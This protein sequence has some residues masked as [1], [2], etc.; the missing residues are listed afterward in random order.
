MAE[1]KQGALIDLTASGKI[2]VLK[3]LGRG[4]QGIV[5]LSEFNGHK[6]ALK[7]YTQKYPDSFY[8]NIK[9][10]I[11]H[12]PPSKS[13]LWPLMLTKKQNGSFGYVMELRKNDFF[14]FGDYLLAKVKFASISAMINAALQI[15]EGF[16][17]LHLKGFSYQDLNDGNFFI[18]PQTGDVLICDNDNVTAQGSNTGIL[19]KARYMAPEIVLGGKPDKYS[20]YYSLAVMLFMLFYGNHPLEGKKVVNCPCMTEENERKHFGSEA[21]FIYDKEKQANLPV[22]GVHQNVMRRWPL[23][24]EL[25][26]N[27]FTEAFSQNLIKNPTSR[28]IESRWEKI[29]VQ[30]RNQLIICSNCGQETFIDLD[31]P[32]NCINCGKPAKSKYQINTGHGVIALSPKK[33]IFLGKAQKPVAV[34]RINKKDPS[35]WALQNLSSNLWLIETPDGK[36]K[37]LSGK[38]IMPI[39]PGIKITFSQHEK[40]EIL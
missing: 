20:D 15:C 29:F 12:G 18:N 27:A 5:Y 11:D 6:Y 16:Y 13:F 10:N 7:W 2:K 1:L 3:E 17:Y 24:T 28:M 38:E 34:V 25:L 21:L 39:K 19:G 40:G 37:E 35:I 8:D 26:Q 33:M 22:R 31:K 23:F 32:T 36:V 30:L 4:G 9:N 14:E